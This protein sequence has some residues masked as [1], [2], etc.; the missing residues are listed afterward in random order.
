MTFNSI[1]PFIPSGEDFDESKKLFLE[2]GFKITWETAD[3]I[4]FQKDTCKFI[5]QRFN[6]KNFSENLMMRVVVES[7]D[8]YWKELNQIQLARKFQIILREPT[9]FHYGR[10]IHLIDL[11]GV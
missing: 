8:E 5:M 3:Y 7:L 6:D 11:A 2:M 4:G 9:E 1:E 10:E